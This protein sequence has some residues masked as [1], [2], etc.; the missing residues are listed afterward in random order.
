VAPVKTNI[1]GELSASIVRVRGIG[2]L[3]ITLAVTSN[4]LR[5]RRNKMWG[6]G[7]GA[8]DLFEK[9]CLRDIEGTT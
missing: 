9:V 5:L 3:G 2:E 6:W 8:N 1:S 4:R 7:K